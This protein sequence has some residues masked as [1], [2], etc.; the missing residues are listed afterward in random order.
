MSRIAK[1]S[2]ILVY[3]DSSDYSRFGDVI[4]GKSNSATESIFTAL[5]AH[6]KAGAAQFAYSVTALS[7]LFQFDPAYPATTQAKAEA[8][9]ALCGKV[10]FYWPMR[11]IA[12]D[13]AACCGWKQP[14]DKPLSFRS[15]WYPNASGQ[16]ADLRGTLETH[17]ERELASKSFSSR[18]ERRR[19]EAKIRKFR[20]EILA[21]PIIEFVASTY[22]LDRVAVAKAITPTLQGRISSLE[23]SRR[24]FDAISR[25]T[26]FARAYF[27]DINEDQG[28]PS[29]I[30]GAG[31]IMQ[32]SLIEMREGLEKYS[33][34]YSP[35]QLRDGV[36]LS[37]RMVVLALAQQAELVASEFASE[38]TVGTSFRNL[39]RLLN[40]PSL[41]L[42]FDA[43][44][45]LVEQAAGMHGTGHNPERSAFGDLI[46]LLY[47]PH[48]D[49]WRCDKRFRNVVSRVAGPYNHALVN[50]LDDLPARIEA[51]QR[52]VSKLARS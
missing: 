5:L 17:L 37:S 35:Q 6:R 22:Q 39:E 27:S 30:S 20:F 23:G 16:L 48:A 41:R 43:Y 46:H 52:S 36:L 11:S 38:A 45:I 50:R 47:L 15:E 4:R 2:P 10:A 19:A 34:D 1:R 24:M 12:F 9:E 7:E 32:K 21:P 49:L 51:A 42:F 13:V 33:G 18:A 25:P 40:V 44:K 14:F 28:L 26:A 31:D 8:V 3:L 29:W